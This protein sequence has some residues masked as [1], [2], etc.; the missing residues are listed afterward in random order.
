MITNAVRSRSK[1]PLGT[2]GQ[3]KDL[4]P[5]EWSEDYYEIMDKLVL[6]LMK[7]NDHHFQI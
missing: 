6:L 3:M 5:D 1:S 4:L 7:I 2:I